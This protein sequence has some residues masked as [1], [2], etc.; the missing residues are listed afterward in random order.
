MRFGRFLL[1]AVAGAC[2]LWIL[3]FLGATFDPGYDGMGAI[4]WNGVIGGE[5]RPGYAVML[6]L[7]RC[8]SFCAV[9]L[10]FAHQ[11]MINA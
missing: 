6:Y 11:E 2:A 9:T 7:P 1:A 3:V 4:A 8:F 5:F 10:L